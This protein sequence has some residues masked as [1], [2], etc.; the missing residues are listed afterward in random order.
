MNQPT[1]PKELQV[2]NTNPRKYIIAGL[3]IIAVFFG[4]L[5]AWAAFF[6]FSGAVIAP[7]MVKVSMERKIVQHLEGGIVDKIFVR[8]G[9]GVEKGQVL[10]RLK[11]TPVTTSVTLLQGQL[12]LKTAEFIRLK[13]ESR[14]A[15]SIVWPDSLP[16]VEKEP[17]LAKILQEEEEVFTSRKKNLMGKTR[18]YLSQIEQL[19]Q[20]ILGAKEE[21]A[22]HK[23]II[24]SIQE[25]LEA[26]EDLYKDRYIDKAQLLV[27]RRSLA[28][29]EGQAGA[30]WQVIAET[31]QK[32]EEF[33][34]RIVDLRNTYQEEAVSELTRVSDQ[35][36]EIREKLKPTLDQQER[37]EIRAPV[38][39]EVINLQIHSEDG[40]VIR[41]GDSLMDI[42]P[43]NAELIVEARIRT[44]DITRVQK[45]QPTKVQLTAFNRR[46]IPPI[47]GVLTYVSADQLTEKTSA[48]DIPYY[49]AHVKV[50]EKDLEENGAYLSP[51][52]PAICYITTEMR[53]I[54]DY[55]LDPIL[56]NLDQALRETN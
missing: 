18:L 39:G 17:S 33:K 12:W 6:P 54:M 44:E 4:G 38:S 5:G 48:G 43:K 56:E 7:G 3:M 47:E 28:E 26:K 8:E 41:P 19:K 10:V 15:D 37:L 1:V 29:R 21:M 14:F 35:I 30:L 11:S 13:A 23:K 2:I 22:A 51:G 53:T 45:G 20:K 52:M 32:I 16:V 50:A 55:L 24:A 9:D 40:G 49:V 34:L 36:F 27:L 31:G 46:E 42:V 25:E